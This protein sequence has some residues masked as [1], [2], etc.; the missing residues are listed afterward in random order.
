ML[1]DCEVIGC[2]FCRFHDDNNG[3][4]ERSSGSAKDMFDAS[5]TVLLIMI[6]FFMISNKNIEFSYT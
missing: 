3:M 6:K 2:R 1:D 4:D 5:L